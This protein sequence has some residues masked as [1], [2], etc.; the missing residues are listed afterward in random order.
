MTPERCKQGL[1]VYRFIP[2]SEEDPQYRC[3][4][5]GSTDP[6]GDSENATLPS[7]LRRTDQT[8]PSLINATVSPQFPSAMSVPICES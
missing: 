3:E 4:D 7:Y 8:S 2:G 1:H 5:C 6:E